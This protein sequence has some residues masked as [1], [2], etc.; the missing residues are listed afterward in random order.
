MTSGFLGRAD[1]QRHAERCGR[2]VGRAGGD[3]HAFCG[4]TTG[5]LMLAVL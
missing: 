5:K 2:T 3:Q 4:T 1:Q